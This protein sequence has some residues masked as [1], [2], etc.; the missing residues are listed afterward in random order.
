[1]HIKME[2]VEMENVY[3]PVLTV[4]CLNKD[5]R[6]ERAAPFT[7]ARSRGCRCDRDVDPDSC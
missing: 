4:I 6:A 5:T 3:S 7:S 2:T 1:M